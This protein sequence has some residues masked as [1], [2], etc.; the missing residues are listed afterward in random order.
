MTVAIKTKAY[1]LIC[2]KDKI[3]LEAIVEADGTVKGYRPLGGEVEF[4]ET[5]ETAVSRELFEELSETITVGSLSCV[6][7]EIFEYN[8]NPGHEVAF[9][10]EAEFVN[11]E[12]YKQDKIMR[13]D[14]VHAIPIYAEWLNPHHLPNGLPL[15]PNDFA[16]EIGK[17]HH[18]C[19]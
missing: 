5:A 13:V 6:A 11:V 19:H 10:F 4:G 7:E 2:N 8:G 3:L 17:H 9:I 15:F 16:A 1:A 12:L 18:C 14:T